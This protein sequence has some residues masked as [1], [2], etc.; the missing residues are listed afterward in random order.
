VLTVNAYGAT[1]AT[2][3]L[4]PITI[5]RR[6]VGPRDVFIEISTPASAT[7]TSTTPAANGAD[8]LPVIPGHE[9]AGIVAAVGSEVTKHAVGDR[10]GVGC[11][12]DSLPRVRELPQGRGGSNDSTSGTPLPP[13]LA[14]VGGSPRPD[15]GRF[16]FPDD[17]IV[18]FDLYDRLVTATGGAVDPLVGRGLELLG[19]D[20][21]YSLVATPD[22]V[23]AEECARTRSDH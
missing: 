18:L 19:Y 20:P 15:G 4:T 17:S 5:E 10:V 3:P 14:R 7:P 9:I 8:D 11:L 6:E 12:V 16:E 2:E 13:G 23:R 21:M 22:A 1:S